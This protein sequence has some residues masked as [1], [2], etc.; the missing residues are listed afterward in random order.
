MTLPEPLAARTVVT[1]AT[2][3]S[4]TKAF[5]QSLNAGALVRSVY[6]I[7]L[8]NNPV[9]SVTRAWAAHLGA[10]PD[11]GFSQE[12]MTAFLD[13]YFAGLHAAIDRDWLHFDV[14]YDNLGV[15]SPLWTY[16]VGLPWRN[17]LMGYFR[18]R[19]FLVVHLVREDILACFASNII[20]QTRNLYHTDQDIAA[21][22]EAPIVLDPER[23]LHYV[24]PVARTRELVREAFRGNRR[25]IELT[26]PHFIDGDRIAPAAVEK[27]GDALGLDADA[28]AGL[29]GPIRMRPTAPDKRRLISNY[30]EVAA[31]VAPALARLAEPRGPRW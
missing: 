11:F 15:L 2:Q 23:A 6:E 16:P 10:R 18:A 28:A 31:Y 14:M 13:D 7:F 5:A 27:L 4:G 26:Y 3:R 21:R 22:E 20:A 25:C 1:I 8:P 12:E 24:L 9:S 17:F 30:D 19:G 29:F